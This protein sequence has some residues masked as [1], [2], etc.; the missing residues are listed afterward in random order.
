MFIAIIIPPAKKSKAAA[1]CIAFSVALSCLFAYIPYL[2]EISFG[3]R[4]IIVSV[5]GAALCAALFPVTEAKET[6]V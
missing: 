6:G 3:F 5:A 4:V 2:K 1:F